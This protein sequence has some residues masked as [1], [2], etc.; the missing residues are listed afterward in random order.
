MKTEQKLEVYRELIGS[1]PDVPEG[2]ELV[3]FE[4]RPP[5]HLEIYHFSTTWLENIAGD[6]DSN[7]RRMVA[8]FKDT[9]RADGTPLSIDPLPEVSG[10]LVE[11]YGQ[12]LLPGHMGPAIGYCIFIGGQWKWQIV[13]DSLPAGLDNHYARLYKIAQPT[14]LADLVGKHGQNNVWLHTSSEGVFAA[15]VDFRDGKIHHIDGKTMKCLIKYAYRWS[16][17]PFTKY[18]DAKEFIPE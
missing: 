14:T 11:Y 13:K 12:N 16:N 17:D 8:I 5:K 9:H 10:C 3:G 7:D 4:Y 1:L 2:K 6:Y 15:L 18:A